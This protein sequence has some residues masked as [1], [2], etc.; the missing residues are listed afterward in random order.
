M[1]N[2]RWEKYKLLTKFFLKMLYLILTLKT[3]IIPFEGFRVGKVG[4][5]RV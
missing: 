5:N 3:S 4:M 2:L 1:I